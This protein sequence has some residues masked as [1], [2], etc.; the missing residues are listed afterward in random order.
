VFI[1]AGS[2]SSWTVTG[3]VTEDPVFTLHAP[4]G[5][6]YNTITLPLS[7]TMTQAGE[8]G[9][10]I[11]HCTAVKRWNPSS[12]GFESIAFKIGD[13]WYG[14]APLQPGRPYFVNVTADGIWPTGK[15]VLSYDDRL[16]QS[17]H[18]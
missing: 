8:L 17:D 16:R 7:N 10:S 13:T 12:Q 15:T 5:N 3:T 11:P 14:T 6:G 18:K 1:E 9:Q 4:G 2:E